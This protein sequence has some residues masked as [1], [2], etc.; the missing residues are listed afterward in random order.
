ME[1]L[2]F[3]IIIIELEV[4]SSTLIHFFNSSKKKKYLYRSI[5]TYKFSMLEKMIGC[6][7]L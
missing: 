7:E 4:S 2:I 3:F 1:D 5:Y 6:E